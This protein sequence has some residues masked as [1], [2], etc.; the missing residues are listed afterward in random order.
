MVLHMFHKQYFQ[1]KLREYCE[2]HSY[3]EVSQRW[4]CDMSHPKLWRM[5][6]ID[7]KID[8]DDYLMVCDLIDVDP[9]SF[10]YHE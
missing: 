6:N 3:R 1:R 5:A 9:M 7:A 2:K 8:V 4:D 10:I